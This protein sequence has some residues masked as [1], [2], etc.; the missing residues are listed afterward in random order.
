MF[1]VPAESGIDLAIIAGNAA[2][3]E[4]QA[5]E[6]CRAEEEEEGDGTRP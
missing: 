2:Q 1:P 4:N 3:A 6:R 5:R